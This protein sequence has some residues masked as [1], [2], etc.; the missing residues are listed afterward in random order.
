VL[1]LQGT[2]A[3]YVELDAQPSPGSTQVEIAYFGLLPR[4]IGRGL[5]GQLLTAGITNAWSLRDRWPELP[6][7]DRVWVHTCTLDGEYALA[8]Y[9]ARG[10]RPYRTHEQDEHRPP[11]P[12]GPWPGAR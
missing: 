5:G 12:P 6:P 3:G 2:P 9:I 1:W 10:L 7:V 11:M 8:N 4:F